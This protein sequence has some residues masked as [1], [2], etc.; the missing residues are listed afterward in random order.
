MKVRT[1]FVSNSSTSSF[2]IFGC[3]LDK[4]EVVKVLLEKKVITQEQSEDY[5]SAEYGAEAIGDGCD[6]EYGDGEDN[7]I[8]F[9]WDFTSIPDDVVVGEWKKEKEDMVKKIFGDDVKCSVHSEA[10]PNY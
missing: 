1:G 8:Y 3:C 2:I 5:G 6:V 10:W 4:E 9:G 7:Y